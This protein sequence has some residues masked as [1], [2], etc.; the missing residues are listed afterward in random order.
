M[1]EINRIL[2]AVDFSKESTLATTFAV[3]MA[4]EYKAELYV[5]HVLDTL[6]L[7]DYLLQ[8][9]VGDS[10]ISGDA[11]VPVTGSELTLSTND[12]T[13]EITGD[14]GV[15]GSQANISL[16]TYSVS[17][18]GNVSVIV[19]EHDIITSIG[20]VT[21]TANADVSVTG[22]QLTGS[23]GDVSFSR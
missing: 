12:V 3:S 18:D 16:G 8:G 5:L 21:T 19:T 20:S 4:Q 9:S 15:I 2:V 14:I 6:H 7:C 13:F 22:S 1:L 11:N 17:A 10:T 23:V